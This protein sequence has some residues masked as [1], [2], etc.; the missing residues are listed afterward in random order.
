ML[1]CQLAQGPQRLSVKPTST[2]TH[3]GTCPSAS[4]TDT[5]CDA[6]SRDQFECHVHERAPCD[7]QCWRQFVCQLHEWALVHIGPDCHISVKLKRLGRHSMEAAIW[8]EA[9]GQCCESRKQ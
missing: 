1:R 8:F 7:A 3:R 6:Q 5:P 9:E 4:M 2:L